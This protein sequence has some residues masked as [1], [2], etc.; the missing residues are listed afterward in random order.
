VEAIAY[1]DRPSTC[2]YQEVAPLTAV[3]AASA[4]VLEASGKEGFE[5][6]LDLEYLE[7]VGCAGSVS[8][9]RE[10]AA[11]IVAKVDEQDQQSE[12]AVRR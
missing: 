8:R 9:W 4:L 2:S 3:H 11:R 12:S 1:H 10:E 5:T 6:Q 7:A